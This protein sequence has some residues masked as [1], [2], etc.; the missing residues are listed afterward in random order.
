[1]TKMTK[2][3]T[4]IAVAATLAVA[5]VAAPQ[6]AEARGGRIAAGI[7]GGLAAGAIIG[8]IASQNGY[9]GGPGLRLL[10]SRPGLLRPALLLDPAAGLGRLRLAPAPRAG[11]RLS[12]AKRLNK[13]V[14]KPGFGNESGLFRRKH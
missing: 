10:R 7:I 2:S 4:A 8:G 1:M 9:Y 3:L 6:P 11:L 12:L 5:A 14:E 13:E